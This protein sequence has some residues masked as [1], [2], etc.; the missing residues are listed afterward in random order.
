MNIAS[1]LSTWALVRSTLYAAF[2]PVALGAGVSIRQSEVIDVYGEGWTDE[3]FNALP[4]SELTDNWGGVSDAELERACVAH[5]DPEGYRYYIPALALSLIRNPDYASMRFIGTMHSF[6][7]RG[8][9]DV[10][11]RTR[12][13]LLDRAQKHAIALYLFHLPLLV[14][15]DR[16]DRELVRQTLQGYWQQFLQQASVA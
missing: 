1:N 14:D 15:L 16:D 2:G 12:F 4:L 7:L 3:Q 13:E 10:Y 6:A 5:L 11:H 9:D 8:G